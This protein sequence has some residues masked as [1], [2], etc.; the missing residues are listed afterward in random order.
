MSIRYGISTESE[1]NG[2]VMNIL[3]GGEEHGQLIPQLHHL[4]C[5]GLGECPTWCQICR[6]PPSPSTMQ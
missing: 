5:L 2:F 1:K 6:C 4:Q 3:Q